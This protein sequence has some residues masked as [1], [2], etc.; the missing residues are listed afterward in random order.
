VPCVGVFLFVVLFR[1]LRTHPVSRFVQPGR[2][3]PT[4]VWSIFNGVGRNVLEIGDCALAVPKSSIAMLSAK[5]S[6]R[7]ELEASNPWPPMKIAS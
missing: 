2:S 7:F 3:E 4:K 6:D 5:L 1:F